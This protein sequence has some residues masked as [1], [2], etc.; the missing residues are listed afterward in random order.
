MCQSMSFNLLVRDGGR[1]GGAVNR[2]KEMY[3]TTGLS[4]PPKGAFSL[5]VKVRGV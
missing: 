5:K 2:R 4:R 1:D 3:R